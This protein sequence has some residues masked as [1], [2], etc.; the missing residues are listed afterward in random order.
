ML[1]FI[2][3]NWG[4]TPVSSTSMDNVAG[5]LNGMFDFG[6]PSAPKVFL[7]PSTGL[8]TDIEGPPSTGGGGH[9]N[10]NGNGNGGGNKGGGTTPKPPHYRVNCS[11]AAKDTKASVACHVSGS[12]KGSVRFRIQRGKRTLG[13]SRATI[14]HGTAKA[15]IKTKQPLSGKYTLLVTVDRPEGVDAVSL[16]VSAPTGGK[17]RH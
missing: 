3:D 9:G 6:S 4:L 12:G 15:T 13:T 7:D 2:E 1:R 14:K 5:S 8:V 16:G 11:V 17:K 10:G